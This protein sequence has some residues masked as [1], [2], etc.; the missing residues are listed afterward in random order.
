MTYLG[1]DIGEQC[2]G[3]V[4]VQFMGARR[5]ARVGARPQP[6]D[7]KKNCSLC[8]GGGGW[9]SL[10]LFLRVWPFPLCGGLQARVQGRGPRGLPPPLEIEKQK[11]K[12]IIKANF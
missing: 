10:L 3:A 7:N 11:K 8:K 9:V 1:C 5:G 4:T 6:L 12:K 2:L